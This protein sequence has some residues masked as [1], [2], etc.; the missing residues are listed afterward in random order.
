M[1]IFKSE[2]SMAYLVKLE[3]VHLQYC[4]KCQGKSSQKQN[5][6]L[7]SWQFFLYLIFTAIL[8]LIVETFSIHV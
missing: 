5:I 4:V 3:N 2:L 1:S 8:H 6:F 7:H